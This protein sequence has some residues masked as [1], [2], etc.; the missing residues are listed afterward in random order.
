V[1][2]ADRFSLPVIAAEYDRAFGA[3]LA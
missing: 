2:N 1:A 3:A